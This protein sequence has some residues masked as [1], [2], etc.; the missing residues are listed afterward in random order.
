MVSSSAPGGNVC[1]PGFVRRVLTIEEA[2]AYRQKLVA[3]SQ[4]KS[5]ATV[6]LAEQAGLQTAA[7]PGSAY[8][9]RASNHD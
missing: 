4:R 1:L 6:P 3:A 2:E 5:D 8:P 9:S 7:M